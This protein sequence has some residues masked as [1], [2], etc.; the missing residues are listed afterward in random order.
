MKSL[1]LTNEFPP[2]IYGGAG[3]HVQYL[4]R[5][6][7]RLCDVEVRC[8]GDQKVDEGNPTVQG[9]ATD[10]SDY[11]SPTAL[12]SVF[13]ALQNCLDFNTT[14]IDADVVHLHTW[15]S[16]F[17]GVLA[18][19]NYGIPLV[20]TVHSLEPLRPWKREQL[21]GGYDFTLWLEKTAIEMADAVIA[22]SEETREDILRHFDVNESKVPVIY[23]GIDPDE[24]V[25][26]ESPEVLEKYSINPDKPFVLFVGRITRQK[27]IIHLVNA[28]Q[29]LDPDTQ[30]VLCAGA[31]DTQDIAA[32]MSQAVDRAREGFD[33]NIIWIQEMVSTE[34]KIALYS[35]AR[36]FC[37]PSI[38]EPFGIINLE[39]MA[40]ETPVVAS[41]VGG[42]KEIIIPGETGTLVPLEQQTESPF[43]ATDP[44]AF[45]KDLGAAINE[46]VQDQE[47]CDTMGKAGRQ[48]VLNAFS[49]AEIAKETLGLYEKVCAK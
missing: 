10:R 19:L 32:E 23:N 4:S 7:A 28:I 5:E 16:H 39:A 27:G 15:Y 49:W 14:N 17:G 12:H 20:L 30:V 40:C 46:L 6:L 35:H 29:H 34:E 44:D 36:V 3:I 26:T 41:E 43:E 9:F 33:G 2:N 48:R 25:P 8:F 45:A 13:S 18:K 1:L 21:D 22:V 24:Y 47:R 38:Y 42:M 31:P 37:C 11:T